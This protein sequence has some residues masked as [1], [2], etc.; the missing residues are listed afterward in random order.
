M[1]AEHPRRAVPAVASAVAVVL[2]GAA[3]VLGLR[4]SGTIAHVA[5]VLAVDIAPEPRPTPPPAKPAP[6]RHE[7]G[8]APAA[9]TLAHRA[10]PPPAPTILPPAPIVLASPTPAAPAAGPGSGA[11]AGGT[12]GT[13]SG[14]TGSGTGNGA[15]SGTGAQ[16]IKGH[17]MPRDMLDHVLAPGE[18]A[19]V[20]IRYTVGVD[21]RVGGCG[22]D[23]SSGFAELDALVCKLVADRFRFRPALDGSGHPIASTI[24]ETHSWTRKPAS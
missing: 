18:T 1:Y 24:T 9:A 11:G 2:I 22:I 4:A 14:G 7:A 19:S 5:A 23:H 13:G 8:G 6:R 16:Q 17:L 10:P 12:G 21:G 3:L 15:G 20:A